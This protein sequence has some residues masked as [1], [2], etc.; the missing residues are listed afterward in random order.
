MAVRIGHASIGD[1]GKA[2]GGAAGDQTGQEVCIR[3]WYNG[4]WGFLARARDA[5]AAEKI[6]AACEAGCANGKIGYDQNQRN[7]LDRQAKKVNYDLSKI[8]AVCETD[9]SAFV[10]VCVRAAGILL[11]DSGGNAPTTSTLKAALRNTGAFDIYTAASYLTRSSRLRRGDILVRPGKHTVM[12]LDDGKSAGKCN[13]SMPLLT[14]GCYGEPVRVLQVLLNGVTVDAD[15]G[16]ATEKAVKTY[17][18]ASTLTVDGEAGPKTW[19][20]L[21]GIR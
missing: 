6:A 1:N 18:K 7:T 11:P 17:Q 10:T 19:A 12:V 21:L 13:L 9:C 3:S 8:E 4:K 15:F 14:K 16:S 5:D 20:S 2:R